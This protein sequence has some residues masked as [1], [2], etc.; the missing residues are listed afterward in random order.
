MLRALLRHV[1]ERESNGYRGPAC[2]SSRPRL[3]AVGC[4]DHGMTIIELLVVISVIAILVA[5]SAF[6]FTGWKG[7][8][9]IEAE[10]KDLYADLISARTRAMS[11]KQCYFAVINADNYQLYE[12]ANGNCDYDVG[13][14]TDVFTDPKLLDHTLGWTGTVEFDT[15]GLSD[16]GAAINIYFNAITDIYPD[17]DCVQVQQSRIRMGKWDGATCKV[18]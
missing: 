17:N 15:R 11:R 7:S 12:D 6:E 1:V 13:T 16:S 10:T 14:D 18:D 3:A 4:D 2:T 9:A 8:Y 5:V